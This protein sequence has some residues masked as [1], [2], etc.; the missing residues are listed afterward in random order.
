MIENDPAGA[1][2]LHACIVVSRDFKL[3][4]AKALSLARAA[5]CG[6]AVPCGVC[7]H[8]QLAQKGI[9]PDIIF[10]DRPLDDKGRQKREIPVALIRHMAADAWVLPQEAEKKVYLIREADK[11]NVQAQNA[12]L[13]ILEE[14]PPY[15][16][17]I[18]GAGSCEGL[19][20]T[21]RSRCGVLFAGDGDGDVQE[22]DALAQEYLA[23]AGKN[24]AAGLCAFFAGCESLD[25]DRIVDMLAG[26]RHDLSRGLGGGESL[27]GLDRRG[28]AR[29]L[30]L[31]RRSEDYLK[32]NVS[33]KH[34]LGM[35]CVLTER[36]KHID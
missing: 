11:M 30:Q 7:R 27:F 1:S 10:I 4:E 19:L 25:S 32:M 12:A 34:V 17:F 31:V 3:R 22:P 26:V 35:L 16:V 20:P 6:E 24:D 8:C 36:G 13:K 33:V 18:L 2:K 9:H 14:P 29:I 21:V 28:A 5:V 23:L 15:A